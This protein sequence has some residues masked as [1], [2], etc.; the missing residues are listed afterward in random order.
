MSAVISMQRLALQDMWLQTC[1]SMWMKI[2]LFFCPVIYYFGKTF[3]AT[4][5]NLMSPP[6]LTD[7]GGSPVLA[8][9]SNTATSDKQAVPLKVNLLQFR[10]NVSDLR[11]QLHQ[12]R[13]LQVRPL[14]LLNLF[15]ASS[16]ICPF[17]SS[18]F[19]TLTVFITSAP[20]PGGPAGPAE[21]GRAGDQ[22]QTGRGHAGS[23][24]PRPEAES[25]GWG[26]QAQVLGSGGACP[27]AARV[28]CCISVV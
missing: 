4:S 5:Y 25:F 15:Q 17:W 27:H 22:R 1:L 19:F 23:R 13:Q 14:S 10:K 16:T 7:S 24:G 18:I 12:M 11:M 8:P 26:G 2:N 9:K 21:A 3:H 28:N 6:S 20:K